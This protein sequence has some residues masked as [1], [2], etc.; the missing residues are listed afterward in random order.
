MV[1]KREKG[2]HQVTKTL[3]SK[4]KPL[5]EEYLTA[6]RQLFNDTVRFYVD[7]YHQQPN[8]ASVKSDEI[9]AVVEPLTVVTPKRRVVPHPLPYKLPQGFRRAAIKKAVGIFKSWYTNYNKWS[10]KCQ[11][12]KEKAYRKNKKAK[13]TRPPL[14][15]RTYNCSPT[16]YK[17]M[18]KGDDGKNILLKLWTGK[19][20]VWMKHPY[21]GYS[22]P[23][24]WVKGSPSLV[25]SESG[26][27]LNWVYYKNVK[28]NG[29]ITEQI[30]KNGGLKICAVDL[31]LDGDIAVM[32]VL[33]S[34]DQN[35][36][37]VATRFLK[38]N[39]RHQH[40][41]KR[42]LGKDAIKKSQTNATFTLDRMNARLWNSLKNRERYEGERV[43]RRIADFAHRHGCTVIVF[44]YLSNLKPDRN[45]YSRRS[46]QKR[47]YWLKSKIYRRT[48]DKALNDYGI[49]TVRVSPKNTSRIFVYDGT[50][51]MRGFQVSETG[52]VFSDKGMGPLVLT[53]SGDIHSADLNS[54]RNIGIK[55]L[56]KHLEKPT[57]VTGGFGGEATNYRRSV[58]PSPSTV[59]GTTGDLAT[60]RG[61]MSEGY[62]LDAQ[63]RL[64]S[65]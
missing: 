51:I 47:S 65:R 60:F 33:G 34:D 9:Y 48:A 12:E 61:S 10:Y 25:I 20:W 36:R 7:I 15:P 28:S 4:I 17:D 52:F 39:S 27:F 40:R 32:S 46:N 31:N 55:Y 50:P 35:V 8:L 49:L 63:N 26:F 44:E 14:L 6:T 18:Y 16:Y 53:E 2:Y 42:L 1:L 56:A 57:L 21:T 23:T 19:A 22:L 54:A 58:V 5:K 45:K 38:G 64:Y 29:K 13:L 43:S 59:S 41:R 24:E 11:K 3:V 30:Q 37:E 62:A